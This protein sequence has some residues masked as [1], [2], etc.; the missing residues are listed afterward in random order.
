MHA[1]K[2]KTFILPIKAF[3]FTAK[4]P[5]LNPNPTS[6]QL[7]K[8]TSHLHKLTSLQQ[9][10]LS[11]QLHKHTL[12]QLHK[13]TSLQPHKLTPLQLYTHISLYDY[14]L[15][16]AIITNLPYY[17]MQDINQCL[18]TMFQK[19]ALLQHSAGNS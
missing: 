8:F 5:N 16:I 1:I 12:L 14:S 9:Y 7:H 17:R 15:S 19:R 10:K 6:V 18:Q 4:H 11:S 2:S 3:G 13:P